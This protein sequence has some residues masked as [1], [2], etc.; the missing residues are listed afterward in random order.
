LLQRTAR[1][2]GFA[3]HHGL[4]IDRVEGI[5]AVA[6][7]A[8]DLD[9][10]A[11][12]DRGEGL[13]ATQ[14]AQHRGH[15][16]MGTAALETD[17]IGLEN[18]QV[19]LGKEAPQ[20]GF[21]FQI[22]QFLGAYRGRQG[23]RVLKGEGIMLGGDAAFG[24]HLL[25]Q[26]ADRRGLV[27]KQM[28]RGR[29]LFGLLKIALQR[30][31]QIGAFQWHQTLVAL[32]GFLALDRD[33]QHRFAQRFRREWI[34]AIT[35]PARQPTDMALAGAFHKTELQHLAATQ[36]HRDLARHANITG[37]QGTGGGH[38]AQYIGNGIRIAIASADLAPG[39]TEPHNDATHIGPFKKKSA[40]PVA[41]QRIAVKISHGCKYATKPREHR[42]KNCAEIM[43]V[44]PSR[45][46]PR[47][48]WRRI[49]G[50]LFRLVLVFVIGSVLLVG[51]LRFV[52][53]PSSAFMITRSMDARAAGEKGFV[54]KHRW[55]SLDRISKSLPAAVM[56]AEDQRFPDHHGFDLVEIKKAMNTRGGKAKRGASTISQQV[57]KNLFLWSGRS[58]LRKGLEVWFTGLIE[59]T[60]PKRRI[61]EV[62]MNIAEFGDGVYGAE[63][64]AQKYF[65]IPA[66]Q[67]NDAQAAR[68]AAVMP[69]PKR[70]LIANPS[71]YMQKR[72]RW[73]QQQMRQLGGDSFVDQVIDPK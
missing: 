47:R 52:P 63:A 26:Q 65:G 14:R 10:T 3:P 54:L 33:R 15:P 6:E 43:P 17:E 56:A 67:L 24:R 46:T 68:M 23:T 31:R 4:Q 20:D 21:G 70:F 37:E 25:Q 30:K 42:L 29:Q 38:F 58:Y 57:A 64:A 16:F 8:V 7:L 48:G 11:I 49:L 2:A 59:L 22:M 50:W 61:L 12:A 35:V 62:Y 73:I 28:D 66:A 53:P 72:Q 69:N 71:P 32:A 18:P 44:K 19:V 60:W 9:Q 40:N 1:R 45:A 41:I 51:A 36:L 13:V 39:S 5:A 34:A 27:G 55:V